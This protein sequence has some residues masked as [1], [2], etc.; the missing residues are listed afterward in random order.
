MHGL[1]VHLP[2]LLQMS[3]AT[4]VCVRDIVE[5]A[6]ALDVP[7]SPD[8]AS[9]MLLNVHAACKLGQ[10]GTLTKQDLHKQ[11]PMRHPDCVLD[12]KVP[13]S[14]CLGVCCSPGCQL[15]ADRLQVSVKTSH[16]SRGDN[17]A[18]V[19]HVQPL[20]ETRHAERTCMI[21]DLSMHAGC[22]VEGQ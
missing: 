20:R 15:V 22:S 3:E 1:T 17:L 5:M 10:S 18:D 6:E 11:E 13:A 4:Q 7:C 9:A 12:V 14:C 21:A 19:S 16:H 8:A 2:M